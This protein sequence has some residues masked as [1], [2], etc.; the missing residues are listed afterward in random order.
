[1]GCHRSGKST[2]FKNSLQEFISVTR[3]HKF[4]I[5]LAEF[6]GASVLLSKHGWILLQQRQNFSKPKERLPDSLLLINPFTK[7]KI[8]LPDVVD[9]SGGY[10]GSF[11]TCEGY[12]NFVVLLKFGNPTLMTFKIANPG[13]DV[14]TE[15]TY[16]GQRT[17]FSGYRNLITMG[18]NVYCY[19]TTGRM[20]IYNM[21][22]DSW[23][24]LSTLE[25]VFLKGYIT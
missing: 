10:T 23:K 18:Q 9:P 4:S 17:V 24:E 3:K 20:I 1:M 19:H 5:D 13:N 16:F 15:H 11:S 6:H 21:A 25:N 8:K 22:S 12:P 14:W 2:D 7:A